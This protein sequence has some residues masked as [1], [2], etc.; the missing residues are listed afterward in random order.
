VKITSG[1]TS[2]TK[3][4]SVA[5]RTAAQIAALIPAHDSQLLKGF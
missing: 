2:K 3:T 4:I 5:G 1:H